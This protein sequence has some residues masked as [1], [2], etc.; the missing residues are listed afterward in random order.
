MFGLTT[1]SFDLVDRWQ[2]IHESGVEH[3]RPDIVQSEQ[4]AGLDQNKITYTSQECL[5]DDVLTHLFVFIAQQYGSVEFPLKKTPP[6]V[7][8]SHVCSHWRQLALHT[9]ELWNDIHIRDCDV[10]QV[11]HEW[12][13]RAGTSSVALTLEP[14][15]VKFDSDT[16]VANIIQNLVSNFK[17]EIVHIQM[18]LGHLTALSA[19][20]DASLQN[21]ESLHLNLHSDL[22]LNKSFRVMPHVFARLREMTICYKK[23]GGDGRK[24]E[25]AVERL[26]LPWSQLQCLTFIPD[27]GRMRIIDPGRIINVTTI[28]NIVRQIPTLRHFRTS[29]Q[30]PLYMNRTFSPLTMPCLQSLALD[31]DARM[32]DFDDSD[33]DDEM[34]ASDIDRIL[35]IFTCPALTDLTLLDAMPRKCPSVTYEILKRQY[36]IQ[37]LQHLKLIYGFAFPISSILKDAPMLR[38]LSLS[39]PA[40]MDNESYTGISN[41]TLGRHLRMF[42]IAV[43]G[44]ADKILEMVATRKRVADELIENGCHWREAITILKYVRILD[45]R[46]GSIL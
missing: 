21:I 7:V 23:Y 15:H 22:D 38:S 6:Q 5:P 27:P 37:G 18:T 10:S 35:N 42:A 32:H 20:P 14:I 9:F 41:G 25:I 1:Q 13:P 16:R 26:P 4:R 33:D 36:N 29:I 39:H 17:A 12:V 2:T 31:F 11:P 40:I 34:V 30:I 8:L 43:S 19:S 44:T 46:K 28:M 3:V 45:T 24:L